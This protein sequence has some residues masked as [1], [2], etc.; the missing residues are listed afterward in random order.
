MIFLGRERKRNIDMREKH[1]SVAS[2]MCPNWGLNSQ[3]STILFFFKNFLY[4]LSLLSLYLLL[5]FLSGKCREE[6]SVSLPP[7]EQGWGCLS[8]LQ[9]VSSVLLFS[10]H[11]EN[12][13]RPHADSLAK[14][15]R[16]YSS[17]VG[18]LLSHKIPFNKDQSTGIQ[19]VIT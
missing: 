7:R 13:D 19:N 16:G 8:F 2:C 3:P 4:V 5:T 18:K 1:R 14:S 6:Q 11:S 9:S 10:C 15:D 17:P 12:E